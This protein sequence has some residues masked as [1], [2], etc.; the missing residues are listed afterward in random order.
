MTS[1]RKNHHL[2][3]TQLI[4]LNHHSIAAIKRGSTCDTKSMCESRE[5]LDDFNGDA[6]TVLGLLKGEQLLSISL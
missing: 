3:E 5:Q 2:T 1:I 4:E 6:K